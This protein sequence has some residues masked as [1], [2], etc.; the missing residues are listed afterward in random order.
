MNI[1]SA[2]ELNAGETYAIPALPAGTVSYKSSNAAVSVSDSGVITAEANDSAIVTVMV[3][4][5]DSA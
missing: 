1:P 3:K 4:M 2:V 5:T